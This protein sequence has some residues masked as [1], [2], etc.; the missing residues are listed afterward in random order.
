MKNGKILLLM[1]LVFMIALSANTFTTLAQLGTTYAQNNSYSKSY[2]SYTFGLG[3][4]DNGTTIAGFNNASLS[5][6]IGGAGTYQKSICQ[7][8]I[9]PPDDSWAGIMTG[10]L[11]PQFGYGIACD[12]KARFEDLDSTDDQFQIDYSSSTCNRWADASCPTDGSSL[13]HVQ[14]NPSV[15]VIWSG[16]F[17]LGLGRRLNDDTNYTFIK[18][19]STKSS[20][21]LNGTDIGEEDT[22]T[23]TENTNLTLSVADG[24]DATFSKAIF[25]RILCWNAT[26]GAPQQVTT[27][28]TPPFFNASFLNDTSLTQNDGV[29]FTANV[30]D[31]AGLSSCTFGI[32]QSGITIYYNKSITGTYDQCSQNFTISV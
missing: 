30:S 16:S 1:G 11:A 31:N 8:N 29:N 28:T 15:T 26:T 12:I 27:D 22:V 10:I 5:Y 2:S 6:N 14:N 13:G 18:N 32:N 20:Y 24:G 25:E 17:S 9:T 3:C 4:F 7:L 23:A 19:S 21:Y